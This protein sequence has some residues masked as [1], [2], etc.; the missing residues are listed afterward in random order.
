VLF[1]PTAHLNNGIDL[2]RQRGF[3]GQAMIKRIIALPGD[4]VL[5][6]RHQKQLQVIRRGESVPIP[7]AN[8]EV[9]DIDSHGRPMPHLPFPKIVPEDYVFLGSNHVR[10]FD[11]RYYG[12]V[13]QA[14]LTFHVTPF[15]Q[16]VG[17]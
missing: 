16:L 6:D 12:C 10:G 17:S 9:F 1:E 15:F 11:S 7:I 3:F 8:S 14:S 2:G 4:T 13:P 5:Y